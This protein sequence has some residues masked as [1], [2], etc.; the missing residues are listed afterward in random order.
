MQH[1]GAGRHPGY[2]VDAVGQGQA[3]W[4]A[5]QA[6]SYDLLITDNRMPELS[7]AELILRLRSTPMALPVILASGGIVPEHVAAGSL[8]QPV[9][10]LPKPFTSDQLLATVAEVFRAA[11]RLPDGPGVS[12]HVSG[13]SYLHWGIN[14]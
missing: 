9:N 8:R 12:L 13:E 10:A 6:R 11:S 1:A 5:L 14:E 3:G 4:E 2:Q 7:G